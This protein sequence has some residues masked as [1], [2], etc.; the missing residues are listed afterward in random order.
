MRI[1]LVNDDG[2]D[3]PGLSILED[4]ARDITD[5]VWVVAPQ[6]EQSAVSHAVT[7]RQPLVVRRHGERRF[8]VGGTPADCVQLA[9][10]ELVGMADG[11]RPDLVVSGIN[12]GPN[13]CEDLAYS[14]TVGAAMEAA[15]FGIPAVAM[16]QFVAGGEPVNWGV[17]RRQGPDILRRLVQAGMPRG[18]FVNVNFPAVAG[19]ASCPIR[20]VRQGLR[21]YAGG[22]EGRQDPHGRPYYWNSGRRK[23]PHEMEG[24]ETDIAQIRAGGIS[25]TPVLLDWTDGEGI[26]ALEGVFA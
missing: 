14:G 3:A 8:A 23:P 13:L 19:D 4:V 18:R 6:Q 17:A 5:D 7:L 1:L 11:V 16:S 2:I 15:F 10:L 9:L 21:S 12:M 22:F 25:I 26:K 24:G 20:V